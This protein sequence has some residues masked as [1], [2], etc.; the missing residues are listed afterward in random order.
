MYKDGKTRSFHVRISGSKR[1][2]NLLWFEVE[3]QIFEKKALTHSSFV[4]PVFEEDSLC[5]RDEKTVSFHD[6]LNVSKRSSRFLWF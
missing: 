5:E 2:F 3:P 6:R 4:F 1:K